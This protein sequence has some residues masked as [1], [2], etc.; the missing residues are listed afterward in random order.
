MIA[1]L[2][3][4]A[5]SRIHLEKL[6]ADGQLPALNSLRSRGTW[7][8]LETPSTHVEGAGAYSL[9]TGVLPVAMV[10]RRAACP[11]LRRLAGP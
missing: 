11:V 3:F 4:D 2:Q 1:V 7:Y 5:V 9:Y 6:L 8:E 10:G